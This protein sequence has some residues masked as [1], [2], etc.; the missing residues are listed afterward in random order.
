MA[1]TWVSNSGRGMAPSLLKI[2][3]SCRAAWKT[4]RIDSSRRM[5][6][7][8]VRSSPSA[9]GSMMA[10]SEGEAAAWIRHS[11]GQ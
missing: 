2:S 6:R 11:L 7:K 5:S 10:A 3:T 1:A 8:G 9:I 4:L